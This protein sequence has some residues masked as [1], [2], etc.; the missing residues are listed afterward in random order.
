[1]CFHG[2]PL[3]FWVPFMAMEK[4]CHNFHKL[5][6]KKLDLAVGASSLVC[7]VFFKLNL[8]S[9]L[10][11]LFIRR[12]NLKINELTQLNFFYFFQDYVVLKK[13]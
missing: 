3:P 12:V 6:V 4:M 7:L 1:M 10:V 9:D 8:I 2:L 5:H 13:N 11:C